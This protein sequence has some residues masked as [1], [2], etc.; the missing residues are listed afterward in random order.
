MAVNIYQRLLKSAQ[1]LFS[2]ALLDT[3]P[4]HD[5]ITALIYSF[6]FLL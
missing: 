5:K 6:I 3:H 2:I 4:N 1:A